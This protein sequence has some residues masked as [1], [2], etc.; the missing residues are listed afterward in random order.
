MAGERQPAIE[1]TRFAIIVRRRAGFGAKNDVGIS[2]FK[3]IVISNTFGP[4]FFVNF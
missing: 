1:I 4:D 3:V 2:E